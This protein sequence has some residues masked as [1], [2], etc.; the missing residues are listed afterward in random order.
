M[1]EFGILL[2]QFRKRVR[3]TQ[4]ELAERTG[5]SFNHLNQIEKGKRSAPRREKVLGLSRELGL[6]TDE[7]DKLLI[8]AGYAP[9]PKEPQILPEPDE[10]HSL[11]YGSPFEEKEDRPKK[12]KELSIDLENPTIRLVTEIITDPAIPEDKRKQIE[13]EIRSFVK[14]QRDKAKS[15]RQH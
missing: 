7:T 10:A 15:E 12:S 13:E 9:Q 4:K 3:L 6:S 11:V 5:L 2:R 14:W 8:A 1:N